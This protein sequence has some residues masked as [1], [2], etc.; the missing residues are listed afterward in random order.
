MDGTCRVQTVAD[1]FLYTLLKAFYKKTGCPI[2][3]NTSFNVAGSPLIQTK[4]EAIKFKDY[5]N[6]PHL[7]GI[8]FVDD[9]TL[10]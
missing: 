1:G 4:N 10:A 7:G 9:K 5:A 2:L 8:Y 3:L 6:N